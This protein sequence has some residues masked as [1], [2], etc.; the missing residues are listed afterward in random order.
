MVFENL[1]CKYNGERQGELIRSSL[2]HKLE[3]KK[4][5]NLI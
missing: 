1:N 3:E 5:H 4:N 2:G